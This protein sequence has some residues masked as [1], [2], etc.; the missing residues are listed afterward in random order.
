M[1]GGLAGLAAGCDCESCVAP[2]SPIPS[3]LDGQGPEVHRDAGS[4][5]SPVTSLFGAGS[6]GLFTATSRGSRF[7]PPGSC[8]SLHWDCCPG[9]PGQGWGGGSEKTLPSPSVLFTKDLRL[10][11]R[12]AHDGPHCCG[13]SR[14]RPGTCPLLSGARPI[15][16]RE[17]V[18]PVAPSTA[19]G[20]W[21]S[22]DGSS[23]C[24][25]GEPGHAQPC[26]QPVRPGAGGAVAL[27]PDEPQWGW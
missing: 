25:P 20:T 4:V 24:R 15:V 19:P 1:D 16:T 21:H 9:A 13:Q 11:K 14:D 6:R 10:L 5:S 27:E 18:V 17:E 2:P 12:L 26:P 3:E 23:D 8:P 22:G 7:R